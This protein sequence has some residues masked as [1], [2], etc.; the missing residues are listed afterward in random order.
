MG[1]P[2]I[3]RAFYLLGTGHGTGQA[4]IPYDNGAAPWPGPCAPVGCR[5]HPRARPAQRRGG[6]AGPGLGLVGDGGEKLAIPKTEVRLFV[7][8]F[9]EI[10]MNL[11]LD[12]FDCA[13]QKKEGE[14]KEKR[15]TSFKILGKHE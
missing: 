4:S 2:S 11:R 5:R 3:L 13:C 7:R 6:P 1:I 9:G 15:K 12:R 10:A 8:R 14:K